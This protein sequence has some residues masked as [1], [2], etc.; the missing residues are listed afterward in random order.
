MEHKRIHA[1]NVHFYNFL[2]K[3]YSKPFLP[4]YGL[5]ICLLADCFV[6]SELEKRNSL[7]NYVPVLPWV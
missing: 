6:I 4:I 3:V 2:C 5:Q 1:Q 7:R